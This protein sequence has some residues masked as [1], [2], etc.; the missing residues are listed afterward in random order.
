LKD[1]AERVGRS[2]SS[3]HIAAILALL[4]LI[5]FGSWI[6]LGRRSSAA[7]SSSLAPIVTRGESVATSQDLGTLAQSTGRSEV[8]E[9]PQREVYPYSVVP[10][11]VRIPGELRAASE[12]DP[13]VASHYAE[14]GYRNARIVRV[15]QAKLVY[16]S[17]RIGDQIFWTSKRLSLHVGEK[18][19]T[20]GKTTARARC[21]NQVS[22]VRHFMTSPAEPSVEVLDQL[23]QAPI[24]PPVPFASALLRPPGFGF[25]PV[26]PPYGGGLPPGLIVPPPVWGGGGCTPG[27]SCFI[28]PPPIPP[29][30]HV[31]DS[32][33][34]SLLGSVVL[35]WLGAAG[36]YL[37]KFKLR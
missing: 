19:I 6:L 34:P 15:K 7:S 35:F 17:Y 26:P 20:D 12:H 24:A 8:F 5:G 28:P 18:L 13:V 21:G 11:G 30:V 37:R 23:I 32:D 29:P 22:A 31:A 4:L 33:G 1:P 9:R 25:T 2:E 3:R 36:I 14:F 16:V 10:G 27:H